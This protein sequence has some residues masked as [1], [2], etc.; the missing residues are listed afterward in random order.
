[1]DNAPGI[2]FVS[3][4]FL[5]G[6]GIGVFAG[7]GLAL[8]AFAI[9]RPDE[10]PPRVIEV[11]VLPSPTSTLTPSPTSTP[12]PAIRAAQALA[13]QLGPGEQYATVGTISRGDELDVVGRDFDGDWVAI[14]F[15][16]GSSG[17][18]WIPATGVE[19]LTFSG[20]QALAVLLPTPLPDF[21]TPP[22]VFATP[23]TPGTG[24]PDIDIDGTP[25]PLAGTLDMAVL[26]VTS[27]SDG[28]VSVV[29]HNGGPAHLRDDLLVVT[30]RNLSGIG[31]TLS[32]SGVLLAGTSVTFTTSSFTIGNAPESVQVVVDPSS[33]LDDPNR[34]NNVLTST[35]SRPAGVTPTPS[36]GGSG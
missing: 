25:D 2:R 5:I 3:L 24:T 33:S 15:P 22:L 14:R 7:V 12:A 8:L 31:E 4:T 6:F 28:S 1:M 18:G 19:G 30:V 32:Y 10:E 21:P 26:E 20:V 34:A 35:L 36:A 11:P 29:V 17:Q 23:A 16:P 13:V 27:E 9:T